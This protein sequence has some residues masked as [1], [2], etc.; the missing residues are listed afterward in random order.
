[1]EL[2]RE[3][4]AA[5]LNAWSASAADLGSGSAPF[6]ASAACW[7]ARMMVASTTSGALHHS[8]G[9]Q[10]YWTAAEAAPATSGP[11][12]W[13]AARSRAK[14]PGHRAGWTARGGHQR[15]AQPDHRTS[16]RAGQDHP[17]QRAIPAP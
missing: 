15:P 2:G 11:D 13:P 10:L 9:R 12:R 1:M 5:R 16:L 7:W 14:R 17:G 6:R 3:P 8:R 4:A